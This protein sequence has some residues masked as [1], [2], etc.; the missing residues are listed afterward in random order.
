MRIGLKAGSLEPNRMIF[1]WGISLSRCK[2]ERI[3]L[4]LKIS[5]S[6]PVSSTLL[7]CGFL[8]MYSKHGST[9]SDASCTSLRN[10]RFRKQKRQYAPQTSDTNS[11]AVVAYLCWQPGAT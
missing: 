4:V 6:P 1:T 10:N 7:I 2:M 5:E 9:L 8:E 11:R 3:F